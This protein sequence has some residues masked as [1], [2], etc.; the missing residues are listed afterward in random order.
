MT[1]K[2]ELLAVN[3][4]F[5]RAIRDGVFAEMDALWAERREVTCTHPN[6]ATITGRKLVLESWA[7]IL[8]HL[9]TPQIWPGDPI[10]IIAGNTAIVLCVERVGGAELMAS[11]AFVREDGA[12]RM[13]N[14]QAT[15]MPATSAV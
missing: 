12:W 10:P 3:D 4:D 11:N 13:V 6:H 1:H 8:G 15:P 7:T 9:Q 5:Y 2:L 14:H